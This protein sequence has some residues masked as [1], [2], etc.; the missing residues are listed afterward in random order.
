M[1]RNG[2]NILH[3]IFSPGGSLI[4]FFILVASCAKVS[5]PTG[6][7]RDKKP[8]VVIKTEPINGQTN[9]HGKKISITF[10]EFVVL[11][12]ITDKFMVSPP[13]SKRP[14]ISIKGKNVV[15]EYEDDLKDSTTYTL[16]FQDAIRDLNESN[17]IDNYQFVFSTGSVLDSLSVTGNVLSAFS[18]D[19]P[20][21]ALV[22]LYGNK[23]D[24]AFS[25]ALP[26][27]ITKT[28]KTGYFRINNIKEGY[29]RLYAL[30]DA[31]NSK[32][33]N[34][35]DE[36]I[37]F[38]DTIIHI[39]PANNFIPEL[40]DTLKPVPAD[41]KTAD[42][43]ALQGEYKLILFKPENKTRYLTGSTRT[44]QYKL[45]YTLSLPPDTI[46]FDFSIPGVDP[47][48]YFIEKS[49]YGDTIKVWL[50]DSTVYSQAQ[51]KTLIG[52]P[53][54]DSTGN[55][56]RKQDTVA[57]RFVEP[58]APRG[59]TRVNP[60]K[61][62]SVLST[63]PLKPGQ[64]VWFTSNT[65]LRDPDTSKIHVYEIREKDTIPFPYRIIRDERNSCRLALQSRFIQKKEYLFIAD[66]GAFGNLY[67]ETS[68][69][70]GARITVRNDETFSRLKVMLSSFQ[71]D[72]IIQLLDDKDKILREIKASEKGIAQFNLLDKGVY[73]L[74]VIYDLN[75]DGKWT[76][77]DFAAGRQP[78]PVSFYPRNINLPEN[79][80]AD[81]DW[82]IG[83]RNVKKV[84]NSTGPGFSAG[85][86]RK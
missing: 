33:F 76:T 17:P 67:G 52:Y 68:D 21:N 12:K 31:D 36:E 66:R 71:G 46:G 25:K 26:D 85:P 28:D 86:G 4:L 47:N 6:G 27:Y 34:L 11:D 23:A 78:E 8:P 65:P 2:A 54:T 32:N 69:S 20:E 81:Q 5:S 63:G 44:M 10:D 84:K 9:F 59:K 38:L 24:S 49:R 41:K 1:I 60:L 75:G 15:I 57:L 80:W 29:Y 62:S 51:L 45:I 61:V 18:L 3:A 82:D 43:I 72:N 83:E 58:R 79:N 13:M 42:T 77:G 56:V 50:T 14:D 37:A 19:P 73:R 39:S 53:F 35:P 16:Y 40:P 70:T 7:P 64:D 74:R 30:V 48:S 22:L 55:T